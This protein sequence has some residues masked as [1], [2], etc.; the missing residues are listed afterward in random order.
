MEQKEFGD[1][2]HITFRTD[3]LLRT[4]DN[5]A[6]SISKT[7]CSIWERHSSLQKEHV[8]EFMRYL[9][10]YGF[11]GLLRAASQGSSDYAFETLRTSIA[12]MASLHYFTA[13][14]GTTNAEAAEGHHRILSFYKNI[15]YTVSIY[16]NVDLMEDLVL[17]MGDGDNIVFDHVNNSRCFVEITTEKMSAVRFYPLL[18]DDN[19]FCAVWIMGYHQKRKMGGPFI[20]VNAGERGCVGS[21][22]PD[23]FNPLVARS[24]DTFSGFL[25]NLMIIDEMD[26]DE[27]DCYFQ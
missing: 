27:E 9:E 14:N 24:Y 3:S 23:A 19:V 21:V 5:L 17:P 6:E 2:S 13:V 11:I 8:P 15:N 20:P 25:E 10:H 16:E 7:L 4:K 26:F 1:V 22:H 12:G 18:T